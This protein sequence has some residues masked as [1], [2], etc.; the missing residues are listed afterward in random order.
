MAYLS[1]FTYYQEQLYDKLIPQKVKILALCKINVSCLFV[2]NL[3]IKQAWCIIF[4]NISSF[5]IW[6]LKLLKFVTKLVAIFSIALQEYLISQ[7]GVE[8]IAA[9]FLWKWVMRCMILSNWIILK[10]CTINNNQRRRKNCNIDILF[11][12]HCYAW[13]RAPDAGIYIKLP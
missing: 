2:W 10:L 13:D 9:I 5:R 11:M 8:L 4:L 6:H 1:G 12:M 7:F 3:F